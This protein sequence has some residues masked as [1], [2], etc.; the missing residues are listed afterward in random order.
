MSL[1]I[2]SLEE[3][4]EALAK[5]RA[6]LENVEISGRPLADLM[7]DYVHVDTG[8]LQ[9]SIYYS[10]NVVGASAPYAGD[11]ADRGG[12]HDYAELAIQAFDIEAYADTVVEPF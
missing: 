11:E 9:S 10:G 7:R 1:R 8:Y 2:I 3:L 6:N 4:Q 5:I 12:D